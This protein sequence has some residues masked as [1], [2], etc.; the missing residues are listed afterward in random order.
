MNRYQRAMDACEPPAELERRLRERV[1]AA[2]P[3]ASGRVLRPWSLARKAALAAVLI[4]VLTASA[5]AV[6][7]VEW[8]A[9][10]AKRFGAFTPLAESSFQPVHVTAVCDDV[11]LTVR[12][13]VGDSTS[14]S[15]ILDYQLPEGLAP[16]LTAALENGENC[17]PME[18]LYC[19][20][21]AVS[22]AAYQAADAEKWA[23]LDWADYLSWGAGNYWNSKENFLN[24]YCI[25][26]SG[27]SS[28][29]TE[30]Y[31]PETRTLTFLYQFTVR[32][33]GA[34]LTASPLTIA[35][36]PPVVKVD[37]AETALAD[38]PALITLF[39]GYEG[40]ARTGVFLEDGVSIRTTVSRLSFAVEYR[41]A[42][43]ESITEL[44]R[45]AALVMD[46]GTELPVSQ[47]GVGLAG[48]VSRLA[49]GSLYS[50]HWSTNFKKLQ[51]T[52]HITAVRIGER[53][54]P[55]EG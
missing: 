16:E 52:D 14:I 10:F 28:G 2:E 30:G 47:A 4:L 22:W 54:I 41:G 48:G 32:D 21:D 8:D 3:A 26:G 34:D 51:D 49:D 42:E 38:H 25:W 17:F 27:S 12:E 19:P 46:D 43:Y 9:I 44:A 40:A 6:V 31:D 39:P 37:G 18:V 1:L 13:V 53:L 45:D 29:S 33:Q 23:E 5:G 50:I 20:T 36:A 15:Y 35:V 24:F 55:L 11:T 7:L